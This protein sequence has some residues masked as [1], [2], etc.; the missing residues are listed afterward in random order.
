MKILRRKTKGVLIG[1]LKVGVDAP[2]SIQ[3][4]TKTDTKDVKKTVRQINNLEK[5]GC[6]VVRMAVK[7]M[8]S[9]KAIKEIKSKTNIPLVADI[10]FNY[11]FAIEAIKNGIDKIRLNPGN[12]YKPKE[13]REVV[14]LAKKYKIPIRIG[15]NSGSVRGSH[16]HMSQAM[17][18]AACDYIK[19]IEGFDFYDMIISLK[20]SDMLETIDAYRKLAK[21]CDYPFHL[22]ITATGLI[23][24]GI[25]KSSLGIGSL[26]LEGIGDTIRVSLTD[27]AQEEV[28]VAKEIL[29]S[30][31]L[32]NFGPEI[33]S[34]PTCGRCEVN[35][36]KITKEAKKRLSQA[37]I[38]RGTSHIKKI[39]I[40]GC[41]VN[42]PG[43]AKDA[44]LGV[45]FSKYWGLVFKKGKVIKKIPSNRCIDFLEKELLS[46]N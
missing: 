24:P 46:K 27:F 35:L 38:N 18:K 10:H 8:A 7:D 9:A 14:D 20:S 1:S 23:Q 22:G 43:E 33:I 12:I 13:V 4:M 31:K 3:S 28:N 21:L 32:R 2:I 5:I 17:V 39:A 19:L 26:L 40:M 15:V 11:R 37:K 6:Q 44:D 45:A 30:L 41:F 29:Q 25:V 42:G 36:V 34:C 16:K